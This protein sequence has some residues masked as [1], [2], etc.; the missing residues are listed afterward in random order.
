[1]TH[2][3]IRALATVVLASGVAGPSAQVRTAD[4]AKRGVAVSEFPRFV[5]LGAGIYGYE[6]LRSPGFTTVSLIVVGKTGVLMPTGRAVSRR[7]KRCSTRS[8]R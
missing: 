3:V 8:T 1:M 2:A 4:P 5:P 6:E 7:R